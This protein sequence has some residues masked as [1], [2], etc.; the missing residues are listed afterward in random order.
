MIGRSMLP[1]VL[2]ARRM[3]DS[4]G[5]DRDCHFVM[6]FREMAACLR[7]GLRL[8][9]PKASGSREALSHTGGRLLQDGRGRL[10]GED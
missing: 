6:I 4:C 8:F 5:Y 3:P 7:H 10:P 1:G 2:S 9:P